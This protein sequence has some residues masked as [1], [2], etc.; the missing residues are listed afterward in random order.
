VVAVRFDHAAIAAGDLA[1]AR[2]WVAA[3][4][5]VEMPSGGRHREMGTHNLLTATGPD[6]FLEAIAIDPEAAAPGRARWFGLDEPGVRAR[7]AAGPRPHAVVL[8]ADDLDAALAAARG[9]GVDLGAPLTVSRGDLVWR[10]AV[11]EDG[12]VALDGAAPQLME[13]PSGPHPAGRMADLGLRYRRVEMRTPEAAALERLL[14]VLGARE[15][16]AVRPAAQTALLLEIDTPAR[17]IV[18]LSAPEHPAGCA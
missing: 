2:D 5:G 1:S 8:A 10:F 3:A 6:S 18:R 9:A 7:L 15:A 14:A 16:M 4:L 13:W 12:A 11:R 17:G